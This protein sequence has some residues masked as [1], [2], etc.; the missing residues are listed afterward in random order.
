MNIADIAHNTSTDT[1]GWIMSSHAYGGHA[2]ELLVFFYGI[3]YVTFVGAGRE[4]EPEVAVHF[5]AIRSRRR[6]ITLLK[7]KHSW[8][9]DDQVTDGNS[10]SSQEKRVSRQNQSKCVEKTDAFHET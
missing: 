10:Q 7:A 8:M 5:T 6:N 9:A 4:N 3:I 2:L 1:L